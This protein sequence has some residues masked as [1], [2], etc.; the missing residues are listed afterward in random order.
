MLRQS[1][2]ILAAVQIALFVLLVMNASGVQSFAQAPA[3]PSKVFDGGPGKPENLNVGGGTPVTGGWGNPGEGDRHGLNAPAWSL[4][5]VAYPAGYAGRRYGDP[6]ASGGDGGGAGAGGQGG[7]LMISVVGDANFSGYYTMLGA[8][9]GNG[10]RGGQGGRGQEG[11]DAW[12]SGQSAKS[13]D[14]MNGAIG[15]MGGRGAD[16]ADGGAGGNLVL[17]IDKGNVTFTTGTV[18]GGTGGTGGDGGQGGQGGR[19]GMG[20][21]GGWGYTT[22]FGGQGGTG[23]FGGNGGT[24]GAGGNVTFGIDDGMITFNGV[25]FGGTGGNAGIGGKGGLAGL[26]GWGGDYNDKFNGAVGNV[27]SQGNGGNGGVGGDGALTIDGGEVTFRGTTHFGGLG[28]LN[29]DGTRAV[30]GNGTLTMNAGTLNLDGDITFRG[31]DSSFALGKHATL[32]SDSTTNRIQANQITMN[33]TVDIANGGSLELAAANGVHFNG[34]LSIGL[35]TFTAPD[36]FDD[37]LSSALAKTGLNVFGDLTFRQ[38]ATVSLYGGDDFLASLYDG[39]TYSLFSATGDVFGLEYLSFDMSAF[40]DYEGFT[41]GW[42]NKGVMV[43]SYNDPH[44]APE[45]AS[46]VIM[47]LGLAGLGVARRRRN[48]A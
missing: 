36:L 32:S 14:E 25:T 42:N 37:M 34:I 23:G 13:Q 29:A 40:D 1:N 26:G 10:G 9:G 8:A 43:L 33:G 38:D 20:A 30:S 47:G 24:G 35:G 3:T 4:W 2:Q 44:A 46:L 19:G 45:P 21:D 18:F 12:L 17:T 11:G 41:W 31:A 15:G 48:V 27:G 7:D 22:G 16:G 5:D 28:G 39:W 6:G